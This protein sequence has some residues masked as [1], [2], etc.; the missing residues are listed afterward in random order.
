VLKEAILGEAVLAVDTTEEDTT[1]GDT[2]EGDTTEEEDITTM[3]EVRGSSSA[4]TSGSPTITATRIITRTV[5][6]ITTPMGMR[7]PLTPIRMTNL[8]RILNRN[9]LLTGITVGIRKVITRMSQ[10]VRAGG[11]R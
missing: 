3:A 7:I 9:S 5:T 4:D 10:V 8:K 11:R 2:T 1:E 6:P